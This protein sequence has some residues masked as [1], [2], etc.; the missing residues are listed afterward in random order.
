M[1][2]L[3][4]TD[5]SIAG[6]GLLPTES[7]NFVEALSR[8]IFGGG[9]GDKKS[10][11]SFLSKKKA[12]PPK[13]NVWTIFIGQ[14]RSGGLRQIVTKGGELALTRITPIV[15]TNEDI[16]LWTGDIFREYQA[17][18]T[19]LSRFGYTSNDTLQYHCCFF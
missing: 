14:N 5:V 4:D 13:S 18:M 15:E 2:V 12:P 17:T 1:N 10:T 7:V 11:L 9:E 16:E 6:F 8:K 19:Y 3:K